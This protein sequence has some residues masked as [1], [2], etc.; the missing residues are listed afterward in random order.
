MKISI[1]KGDISNLNFYVDAIVN[2]A[3]SALIP[4]GGVDGAINNQAGPKLKEA[5]LKIGGTP[6]GTSVYTQGY[7]LKTDYVIHSVGPKFID[8]NHDE[9]KLLVSAYESAYAIAEKL[10]VKSIAFPFI[11]SGIYGYP[12]TGAIDTAIDIAMSKK[13]EMDIYFVAFDIDMKEQAQAYYDAKNS[14]N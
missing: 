1:I 13:S 2:A 5:M 6:T 8:G 10:H 3:N 14:E 9:K 4:G 12:R 11:S 7:N